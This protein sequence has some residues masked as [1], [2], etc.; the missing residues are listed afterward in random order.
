LASGG[1][2]HFGHCRRVPG[3]THGQ[4]IFKSREATQ[5]RLRPDS[6]VKEGFRKFSSL[7]RTQGWKQEQNRFAEKFGAPEEDQESLAANPTLKRDP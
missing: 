4:R 7:F 2:W 6:V 1:D 3:Y 5:A